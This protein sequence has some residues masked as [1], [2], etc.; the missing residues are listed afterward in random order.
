MALNESFLK[1]SKEP[2]CEIKKSEREYFTCP[3]PQEEQLEEPQIFETN[4]NIINLS[5]KEGNKWY[6]NDGG[7]SYYVTVEDVE[8]LEK[9]NQSYVKFSKGDILKV[10]I[11]R[12]IQ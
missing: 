12:K 11:R 9:I 4:I 2:I 5:F 6:I 3:K 10:K 1:N 8:F 7:E